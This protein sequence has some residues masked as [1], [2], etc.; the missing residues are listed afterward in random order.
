[1]TIECAP[2]T[3]GATPLFDDAVILNHLTHLVSPLSYVIRAVFYYDEEFDGHMLLTPNT[4]RYAGWRY[5]VF[6]APV[7]S[8]PPLESRRNVLPT[9]CGLAD[10]SGSSSMHAALPSVIPS[11]GSRVAS[12]SAHSR[13]GTSHVSEMSRCS[14]WGSAATQMDTCGTRPVVWK[15]CTEA[16]PPPASIF[17]APPRSPI[18]QLQCEI[19]DS[20]ARLR[21]V[22]EGRNAHGQCDTTTAAVA[23]AVS[24]RHSTHPPQSVYTNPP[25]TARGAMESSLGG[26]AQSSSGSR[27]SEEVHQSACATSCVVVAER[28]LDNVSSDDELCG[29]V[30][31]MQEESGSGSSEAQAGT[32]GSVTCVATAG[33]CIIRSDPFPAESLGAAFPSEEVGT[34]AEE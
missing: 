8:R 19:A 10:E 31:A 34:A 13:R 17:T 6:V 9:P 14:D 15:S 12:N 32:A 16:P 23:T 33:R 24:P 4:A 22:T 1:M 21:C 7:S 20:I 11:R 18:E 2:P 28:H 5:R 30:A 3:S 26:S 27:R 25:A 29:L